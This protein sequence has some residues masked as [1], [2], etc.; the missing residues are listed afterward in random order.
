M[1]LSTM[2]MQFV[3]QLVLERAGVVLDDEKRDFVETRVRD[4]ARKFNFESGQ[5]L[6]EHLKSSHYSRLHRQL[7]EELVDD[8]T[9]F[10]R[11]FPVFKNMR[12]ELIPKLLE[13][14]KESKKLRIWCG[15]CSSGQEAYS[16]AIM[17]KEAIPGLKD[18]DV[19]IIGSDMSKK[20]LEKAA[21]AVYSQAEVSRGMPAP[22]LLKHF[23]KDVTKWVINDDH[24][25]IVE[26]RQINLNGKWDELPG[27]WDEKPVFDIIFLRNVITYFSRSV[28]EALLRK[29]PHHM[30]EDSYLILGKDEQPKDDSGLFEVSGED[31]YSTY[32]MAPDRPTLAAAAPQADAEGEA[33]PAASTAPVAPA[34]EA[35][36]KVLVTFRYKDLQSVMD[37]VFRDVDP[38]AHVFLGLKKAPMPGEQLFQVVNTV[39]DWAKKKDG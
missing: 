35:D 5:I 31:K 7:I 27:K 20:L 4:C 30:H 22:L 39:P 3:T 32:Q 15:A 6:V 16:I 2:E 14:N 25:S 26:F 23:H 33:A 1:T 36:S 37:M 8:D 28:R 12:H 29:L 19:K 10:F 34:E 17:M 18:W 24:K 21:D 38:E 13:R 9:H 11:D